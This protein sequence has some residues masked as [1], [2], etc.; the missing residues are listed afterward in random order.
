M[1]VS[2]VENA[3]KCVRWMAKSQDHILEHAPDMRVFQGHQVEE[4]GSRQGLANNMGRKGSPVQC[5]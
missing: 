5:M 4:I 3:C 2:E 1:Y